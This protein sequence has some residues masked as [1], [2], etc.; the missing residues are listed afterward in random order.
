MIIC[1]FR[2]P[3]LTVRPKIKLSS[4]LE[5]FSRVEIVDQY[6]STAVNAK[7]TAAKYVYHIH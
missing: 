5:A 1:C 4:C 7:T 3:A 2:D 6:Y